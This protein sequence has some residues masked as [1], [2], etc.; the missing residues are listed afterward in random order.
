M[1]VMMVFML[2]IVATAAV[3]VMIVMMVFM[4]MIV[5]AAAMF[6]VIVMMV[7][8]L[9]IVAA[10]AVLVMLMVMMLVVCVLQLFQLCCN[11]GLAFHGLHQLLTG[12]L[13]PGGGDHSSFCIVLA[14]HGHSL[15]QLIL[16]NGIGAGQNDRGCGLDLIVI[17]LTEVLGVDLHLASICHRNGIAQFHIL[18]LLHSCNHIRQ[19][20]HAGRFDDHPVGMILA[21]YLLQCLAEVAH[22]AAADAAGVHL[23]DVNAGFLQETA[24][25]ADLAEFI[26]DQHQLLAAIALGDHFLD[27]CC[28]TGT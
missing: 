11:S 9:M 15:V 23:G 19:L 21:D 20:A 22:Q 18:H 12:Q 6:I 28:L 2:M 3:L 26:F 1:I 25:D 10:A 17:E 4:L 16:G 13:I 8:M 27:Q 14:Q 24:V 5:A 7:F